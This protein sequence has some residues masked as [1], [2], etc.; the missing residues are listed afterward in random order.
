MAH[1]KAKRK[2]K[3]AMST[4]PTTVSNSASLPIGRLPDPPCVARSS[5]QDLMHAGTDHTLVVI[6]PDISIKAHL[7]PHFGNWFWD[8]S[9]PYHCRLVITA[10]WYIWKMRNDHIFNHAP[11]LPKVV[12]YKNITA[13]FQQ[14]T[15][16]SRP[17]F[18]AA[19]RPMATTPQTICQ[20]QL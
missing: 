11:I 1:M 10:S 5:H 2:N 7:L 12:R 15:S 19:T 20:A 9:S 3:D 6:F 18:R 13:L 14:N 8:A 4:P 17:C 16:N